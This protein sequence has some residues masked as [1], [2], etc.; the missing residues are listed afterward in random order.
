MPRKSKKKSILT[1]AKLLFSE[2]GYD[3]TG[4]EEIASLT[5]VPK[6]L[7]Y[8]HFKNK[9]DLL[10]TIITEFLS[11]YERILHDGSER[12]IDKISKYIHFLENNKDCARIILTESLK[13]NNNN[14][15]IFKTVETLMNSNNELTDNSIQSDNTAN[16]EHW[17]T[18]FFTSIIPSILFV[19]YEENWCKFFGIEKEE[20]AKDF[21]NAYKLTHGAYH[22]YIKKES[23]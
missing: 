9:E 2:K 3:A 6:S 15:V 11:E 8:Y 5:G 13:Q 7:I 12:G 19:C 22:E 20:L 17:V 4:M 23:L 16:H 10:N 1:T 14:M 21:F 18:E